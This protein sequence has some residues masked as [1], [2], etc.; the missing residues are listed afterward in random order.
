MPRSNFQQ[1]DLAV[2]I[3]NA[4]G[5]FKESSRVKFEF[6]PHGEFFVNADKEQLLR[7]FN[8]LIQ[9]SIQA[10]SDPVEGLIKIVISADES[11]HRIE[12]HDNGK[13][14]PESMQDKVFYPNFTTKSG[15]MGL[16][17]ALVKNIIENAG[18][19]IT[20]ESAEGTGTTFLLV[21]PR[22]A[23]EG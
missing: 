14:I 9:N 12:F 8:N 21:L 1:I 10:I 13:G 18:G 4:I 19:T 20:F 3:N 2:I 6:Q 7:V 23:M 11:H 22:K 5:I 16:G 15:G 17:L